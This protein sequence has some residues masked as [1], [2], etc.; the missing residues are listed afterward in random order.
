MSKDIYG[1]QTDYDKNSFYFVGGRSEKE[2]FKKAFQFV[3]N[4]NKFKDIA[5]LPKSL[6][7]F[8]M[9]SDNSNP[10]NINQFLYG[11]G[12]RSS[13]KSNEGS[14]KIIRFDKNSNKWI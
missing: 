7:F 8:A 12:G 6:M 9:A 3:F 11:F 4:D 5:K 1:H 13:L 14:D 10:S 2:L